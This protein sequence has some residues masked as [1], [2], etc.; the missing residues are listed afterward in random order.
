[1]KILVTGGAG[2]IGSWVVEELC[3]KEHEVIVIDDLT[4]G[5]IE[6]IGNYVCEFIN[7]KCEEFNLSTI[8]VDGIIHL[9]AQASVPIS[10]EYFEKSSTTNIQGAINVVN[11][12][13]DKR[14]PVVYAS[15]SAV[16]GNL[17]FGSDEDG[18]IDLV[19]PYACD[20][21]CME[22]YFEVANYIWNLKSVG[23]RFFNVY[24]PRQDPS[25]QYSGVISI[26]LGKIMKKERLKVN[27]GLQTRDFI[28]VKDVAN[29]LVDAIEKLAK[30]EV[31][32]KISNL[33]SGNSTSVND[34][35]CMIEQKT[36]RTTEVIYEE[37]PLG[38]PI[39][40]QGSIEN[41]E[42]YFITRSELTSFE[43]GLSETID[44]VKSQ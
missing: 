4:T 19:N 32:P 3:K 1:M 42:K 18:K 25:S 10:L 39:R 31:L 30:G 27:W 2:F 9:A 28:F 24:G 40:S 8:Q 13:K 41:M 16:Y 35:L 14:I 15:S 11:Y 17:E 34:V 12:S 23:F 37:L 5:Y 20:K 26:F 38:D 6:N 36:G 21:Y 43:V 44:W 7:C 33:L 22:K 29:V